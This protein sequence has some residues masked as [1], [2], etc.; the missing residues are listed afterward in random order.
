MLPQF[1]PAGQRGGQAAPGKSD[2]IPVCDAT[3]RTGLFQRRTS[4]RT[5]RHGPGRL[6]R[7]VRA[8]VTA[9]CVA[10]RVGPPGVRCARLPA[11]GHAHGRIRKRGSRDR[12]GR[13]RSRNAEGA[14]GRSNRQVAGSTSAKHRQTRKPFATR[15]ASFRRQH[16]TR[17]NRRTFPEPAAAAATLQRPASLKLFNIDHR[18]RKIR[19]KRTKPDSVA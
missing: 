19:R 4:L 3:Q 7:L 2:T 5:R 16:D 11:A 6:E 9:T 18:A 13:V 1:F 8:C 15:C 14:S 10:R 12:K 17:C